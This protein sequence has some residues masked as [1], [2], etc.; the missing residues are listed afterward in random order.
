M[1]VGGCHGIMQPNDRYVPGGQAG[2]VSGV[3]VVT[4]EE[5]DAFHAPADGDLPEPE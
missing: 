5:R 2:L 4:A 3:A 1:A